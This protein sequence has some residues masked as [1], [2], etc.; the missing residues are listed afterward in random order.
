[1]RHPFVFFTQATKNVGFSRNLACTHRLLRRK[2]EIFV[3][4]FL[5]F[6]NVIFRWQDHTLPCAELNFNIDDH[7]YIPHKN[8]MMK[9]Y[10]CS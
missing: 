5:T 8:M 6:Q 10:L 7:K 3:Q 4:N 9:T 1:M 2:R